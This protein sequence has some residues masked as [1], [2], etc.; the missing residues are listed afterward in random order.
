MFTISFLTGVAVLLAALMLVKMPSRH[1]TWGILILVF[2][3]LSFL[4]LGG[5]FVGMTLGIVGGALAWKPKA[6]TLSL[7]SAPE[8]GNRSRLLREP[9]LQ[10]YRTKYPNNPEGILE[11]H[12]DKLSDRPCYKA[13][14]RLR[15][16]TAISPLT[17]SRRIA[18]AMC[19]SLWNLGSTSTCGYETKVP[20]SHVSIS[21]C[22]LST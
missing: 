13:K 8:S 19:L 15:M 11:F 12:I 5:L 22:I 1:K 3:I 7:P 14:K 6:R 18:D 16:L 20:S 4:T 21:T 17:S 9:L 2:S 10:F